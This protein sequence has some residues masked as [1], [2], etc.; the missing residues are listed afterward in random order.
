[1]NDPHKSAGP[2]NKGW[3]SLLLKDPLFHFV[4]LGAI[5]FTAYLYV[6]EDIEVSEPKRI[7]IDQNVLAR[8]TVPFTQSWM[9]KPTKE[10]LNGLVHEYIKEEI[11]YREALELGLDKDDPVIRRRMR[12]KMEFLNQDISDPPKATDA[13][14]QVYLDKHK[15]AF[16]RP[17]MATFTQLFFRLDSADDV[18]RIKAH[19]VELHGLTIEQT[20]LAA[21]GDTTLLTAS[22]IDASPAEV[23]RVFGQE[24]A[25]ELFTF[26]DQKWVGPIRSGFGLHL[27]YIE[28]LVQSETPALEDIRK[29]VERDWLSEQRNIANNRFYQ[30]LRDRYVVETLDA[31]KETSSG[32]IPEE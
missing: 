6:N 7:I 22:M 21:I 1:M 30:I 23:A 20:D 3:F 5:L 26:G 12:Q 27:V 17:P 24:F 4:V 11:I 31:D 13:V 14:L 19:L 10:E 9:R 18:E 2:A 28:K 8:L 29:A 32:K 15:S 25:K 16:V